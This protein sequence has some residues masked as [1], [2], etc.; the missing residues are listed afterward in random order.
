M[1]RWSRQRIA[2]GPEPGGRRSG[3]VPT[4]VPLALL[5]AGLFVGLQALE[6][7]ARGRGLAQIDATRYRLHSGTKW[8]SHAWTEQLERVLVET[9]DLPADDLRVIE[10]FAE[11]V[12]A[13]PFVAEV[14]EP[15]VQWPDGLTLPIRLHEPV[16]CIR[17]GS[18]DFL[19]V[20]MDGTILGGYAFSPHEAY[21]GWLPTLGPHGLLEAE[22][23]DIEPGDRIEV[24]ALRA[25]LHVADSM[26]R[27][28][29]VDDLRLLGRIVI[30]ATRPDAPVFDRAAGTVTPSTLPGGVVLELDQTRRVVFG[31]PP[32]PVL[33][34]ELP[35][36]L[37]WEHVE[38]A[39]AAWG[40]GEEWALLDAR[41]DVGVLLTRDEVLD[42]ERRWEGDGADRDR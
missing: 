17:I 1:K 39:L 19:P 34:G 11:R 36:A 20:A 8:L 22:Q 16:A 9:R 35:V 29:D 32:V 21:G 5:V 12:E 23:G 14:G 7:D 18:R 30:D 2:P 27:Y 25:A 38:S 41:F 28:L 15:E 31:R 4:W 10:D 24:P 3:A 6:R 40:R 26:W 13:L 42:F 33:E 37:K